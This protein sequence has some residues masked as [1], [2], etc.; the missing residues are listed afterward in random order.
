MKLLLS[1][2]ACRPNAGSEP[3]VGW[4]FAQRVAASHHDV[5]V[6][7]RADNREHIEQWRRENPSAAKN[8]HFA[9]HDVPRWV[10]LLLPGTAGNQVR[11]MV[12]QSTLLRTVKPL[13]EEVGGFD[14]AQHVTYVRYWTASRLVKLE[15]VPFIWG[16]VGGAESAPEPFKPGLGF[17][18]RLVEF[19]RE[20]A[21]KVAELDPRVHTVASRAALSIATT[22]ETA[23]RLRAMGA[24]NV[25]KMPEAGLPREEI[26]AFLAPEP[27]ATEP[28]AFI[29]MARLLYW[30]GFHL[31]LAAFA[32]A[33]LPGARYV[34][35]GDGPEMP[36]LKADAQLLGIASQVDFDG[37]L[38]RSETMARLAKCHVLVHPSL[39]DSGGWVCLEAM[40]SGRPVICLD[41]GG[42]ATQV[43]DE[44]G[45]RIHAG[46]PDQAIA[47]MAAAMRRLHDD[48]ALRRSMAA[49]GPKRVV[50][51]FCWDEKVRRMN[52]I[53]AEL[54]AGARATSTARTPV[55]TPIL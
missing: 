44:T 24:T 3:G 27:A 39:H 17:K 43:T 21:R 18:G 36:R 50:E 55:A 30:K 14:V 54:M 52:Q 2:Y 9:Y 40:A 20:T 16:P 49:A 32:Q 47:D 42:P 26:E 1:A 12:W 23:E 28:F 8:L 10:H 46:T 35:V 33:K 53:Y 45:F 51:A 37:R 4:N 48:P 25:L 13:H 11:Y 41:L 7:T 6:V 31:G 29:S 15:G 34:I 19:V 38:P 5:W 22:E